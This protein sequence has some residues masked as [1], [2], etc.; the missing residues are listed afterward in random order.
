MSGV[1]VF[2]NGVVRLE[3]PTTKEQSKS[4]PGRKV[5]VFF[6]S[7]EVIS[8]YKILETKLLSLG[9]ERYYDGDPNFL[10]FHKS[11]CIDLISLPKDINKF[12]S[13]CMYD[14]VM[15]NPNMFHVRDI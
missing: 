5:L 1:W 10:R 11:S 14:I 4:K 8:S 2:R 12:D 6:P 7:G 3:K 15:K 9:W 13:V